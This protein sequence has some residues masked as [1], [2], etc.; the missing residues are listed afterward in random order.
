LPLGPE[1]LLARS[2]ARTAAVP[3]DTI[4]LTNEGGSMEGH[5]PR[6]FAGMGTGLFAGDNLNPRFPDGDGVQIFLTFFPTDVPRSVTSGHLISDVLSVRGSPFEDLG[7]FS[8]QRVT[9]GSFGPD[10][11]DLPGDAAP[12]PCTRSGTSG[13]TCDVTDSVNELLSKGAAMLQFRLRFERAGDGDGA[14][15]LAMFFTTDSNTNEPG[16]FRLRLEP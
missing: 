3:G 8:A 4:V 15:D 1:L 2:A 5:T 7:T 13:I 6:G 10:L 11:F 12:V 16:I 9:Y 14:P